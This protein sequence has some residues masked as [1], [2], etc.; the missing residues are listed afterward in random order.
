MEVENFIREVLARKTHPEQ[1]YKSCMGILS[2][3]KRVGHL[4]LINA[5]RRAHQI[6]YYNYRTIEEILKKHLD[7]YE[8]DPVPVTMPVHDNIRGGTYYQ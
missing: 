8:E 4:R 2:F 6:G 5:C 7:K 1:A 3:A